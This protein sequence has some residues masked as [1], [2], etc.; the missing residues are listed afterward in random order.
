M[1]GKPGPAY[2]EALI[3]LG[4]LAFM[5]PKPTDKLAAAA[6]YEQ[7]LAVAKTDIQRQCALHYLAN[8]QRLG[9]RPRDAMK[10]YQGYLKEYPDGA[11]RD[12]SR[13]YLA[14][15]SP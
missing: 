8:A 6:W 14:E 3:G 15:I 4:N 13:K 9:G 5:S 11:F 7:A 12:L 1:S 10:T 2:C